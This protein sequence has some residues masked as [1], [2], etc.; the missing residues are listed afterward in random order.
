VTATNARS[1]KE[2]HGKDQRSKAKKGERRKKGQPPSFAVATGTSSLQSSNQ[3]ASRTHDVVTGSTAAAAA[4]DAAADASDSTVAAAAADVLGLNATALPVV[5]MEAA[6][7]TVASEAAVAAVLPSTSIAAAAAVPVASTKAAAEAAAVSFNSGLSEA[8]VSSKAASAKEVTQAPASV[9]VI[10]PHTLDCAP[11]PDADTQQLVCAFVGGKQWLVMGAV[12]RQWQYMYKQHI[13]SRHV[14]TNKL[15]QG[16]NWRLV[17]AIVFKIV[18]LHDTAYSSVFAT[19]SL[20]QLGISSRTLDLHATKVQYNAGR[21]CSEALLLAA[22]KRGMPWSPAVLRGVAASGCVSKLEWLL[23]QHKWR[24][25]TDAADCA[26][27]SGS[28]DM[29]M[30][31]KQHKAA[32]TAETALRAVK[33]GQLHVLQYLHSQGC[34]IDWRAASA[35]AGCGAL[36]ILKFIRSTGCAYSLD[37]ALIQCA[38]NSGNLEV[39]EWVVEQGARFSNYVLHIAAV[40]GNAPLCKFLME[41]G[42]VWTAEII[43]NTIKC[44]PELIPWALSQGIT[45]TAEQQVKLEQRLQR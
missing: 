10:H 26:A 3:L 19:Q 34:S 18:E 40:T 8:A 1:T 22:H 28:I 24:L 14:Q 9:R 7:V 32:F 12:C 35:A 36:D 30:L 5:S 37:C 31:L 16:L 17:K 42:C 44:S 33:P 23:A 29:L 4:A 39:V 45:L 13:L 27:A 43:E 25:M 20:L 41:R 2:Q 21:H 11:F 6:A 38:E 15:C